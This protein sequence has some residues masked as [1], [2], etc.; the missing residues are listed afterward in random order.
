MVYRDLLPERGGGRFI[1]SH[2][3]V[4]DGGPVPDYVHHHEVRFQI[5]HCLRG[6]VRVVYEDQGPPFVIEAG[7]S[8]LQPP[9]IRH[10][11][12]ESSSGLE[13][14]EV[15]SP[16]EH[17]TIVDHDLTLP[18]ADLRIERDFAGQYFVRHR[19]AEAAWLD[20]GSGFEAADS[21]IGGATGGLVGAR[22]VRVSG[23]GSAL[24]RMRHDADL[25]LWYVEHGSATLRCGD[26]ATRLS[27]SDAISV[28]AG[29]D[30]SLTDCT[31]GLRFYEVTVPA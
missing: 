10:R 24:A 7:D 13:V 31:P 9:H 8:V 25:K 1:A 17:P 6:W 27:T 18:T 28:P 11:V 14:L 19:L 3:T 2:I 26:T 12:L 4:R 16:A 29:V 23:S 22:T 15:T 30:H 21:G 5:V 20:W